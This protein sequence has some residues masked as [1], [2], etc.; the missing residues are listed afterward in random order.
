M[1]KVDEKKW[2][3]KRREVVETVYICVA[4]VMMLF[5]DDST[6]LLTMRVWWYVVLLK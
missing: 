2:E 6:P 5:Q 3:Q 4:T 1:K